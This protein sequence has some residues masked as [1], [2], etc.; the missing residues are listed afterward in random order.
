VR[1]LAANSSGTK[2]HPCTRL[3]RKVSAIGKTDPPHLILPVTQLKRHL[4]APRLVGRSSP[5]PERGRCGAVPELVCTRHIHGLSVNL[6]LVIFRLGQREAKERRGL[7][8]SGWRNFDAHLLLSGA[9]ASRDSRDRWQQR[10]HH[11]ALVAWWGCCPGPRNKADAARRC[12]FT[13]L[14]GDA[15]GTGLS[16]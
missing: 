4:L 5:G 10:L 1:R 6:R 8:H 14:K 16:G 3:Q 7:Y 9:D 12:F 11:R 15:S 13:K 2:A